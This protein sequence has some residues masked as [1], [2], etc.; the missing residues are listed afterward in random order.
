MEEIIARQEKE[1]KEAKRQLHDVHSKHMGEIKST[2]KVHEEKLTDSKRL[3]EEL[4]TKFDKLLHEKVM[5]VKELDDLRQKYKQRVIMT[6]EFSFVELHQAT[7]G[8][9]AGLKIGEDE[10]ACIYRGFLRNTVVAIKLLHPQSLKGEAEFHQ[11]VI[12]SLLLN[13]MIS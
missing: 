6:T 5:A 4:Q 12:E 1:I 3:A 11:Q 10:F 8:F 9:D 2:I 7:K 13:A